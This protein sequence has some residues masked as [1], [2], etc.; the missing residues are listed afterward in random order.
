VWGRTVKLDRFETV[1]VVGLLASF[2]LIG[3]AALTAH[4]TS[5]AAP[6]WPFL[7]PCWPIRYSKH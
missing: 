7:L 1:I 5:W 3:L 4:S 2:V 6:H